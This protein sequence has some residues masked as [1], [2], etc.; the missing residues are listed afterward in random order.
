MQNT[1]S[2]AA[3]PFNLPKLA[4]RPKS[5]FYKGQELARLNTRMLA[6]SI[7]MVLLLIIGSFLY[8]LQSL[9]QHAVLPQV[10]V[11]NLQ[12]ETTIVLTQWA[13]NQISA[14]DVRQHLWDIQAWHYWLFVNCL[15][16]FAAAI[17]VIPF[18]HKFR[19]TPTMMAFGLHLAHEDG[20]SRF[21]WAS[22]SLRYLATVLA[23]IPLTL[24][25]LSVPFSKKGKA[26]PDYATGQ[27]VIKGP[28]IFTRWR[29]GLRF[30]E[31]VALSDQALQLP[32]N[33]EPLLPPDPLNQ[34][35]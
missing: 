22:L 18:W 23:I 12:A 35:E 16:F 10:N 17:L 1:E 27:L 25:M 21:S 28:N 29:Q 7:D 26:L 8:P 24:G 34:G 4:S 2:K 13:T 31:S 3:F 30:S 6:M 11:Q 19:A 15:Q 32:E 5:K 9:L 33:V 14:G 20:S